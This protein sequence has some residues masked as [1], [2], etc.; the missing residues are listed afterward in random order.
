MIK[1]EGKRLHAKYFKG[2]NHTSLL[3]SGST[4]TLQKYMGNAMIIDTTSISSIDFIHLSG[5][6]CFMPHAKLGNEGE[7]IKDMH[8]PQKARP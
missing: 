5:Y 2:Q 7:K 6:F 4:F 1:Y 3:L 8:C